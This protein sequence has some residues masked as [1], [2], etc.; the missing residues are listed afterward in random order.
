MQK[1]SRYFLMVAQK[2]HIISLLF[3]AM[4]HKQNPR[5][6]K[7]GGI[8]FIQLEKDLL[9]KKYSKN[10]NFHVNIWNTPPHF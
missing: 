7:A 9:Q 10:A 5:Y 3:I 6:L 2:A 8:F 4:S 1:Y